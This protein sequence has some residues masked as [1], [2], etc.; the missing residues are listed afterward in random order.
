MLKYNNEIDD[1]LKIIKEAQDRNYPEFVLK[2]D[3]N[4][5]LYN[6]VHEYECSY[7]EIYEDV[8]KEIKDELEEEIRED[9]YNDGY[10]EG[11][12][13]AKRQTKADFI[14]KLG[15]EMI[16]LKMKI[17]NEELSGHELQMALTELVIKMDEEDDLCVTTIDDQLYDIDNLCEQ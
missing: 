5:F 1:L 7:D 2:N 6:L 3:L 11:E 4:K 13:D 16:S 12:D 8:T 14:E 9:A 10:S 17:R 15:N